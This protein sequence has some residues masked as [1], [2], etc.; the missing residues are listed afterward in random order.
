MT[1]PE[2]SGR[3]VAD[4]ALAV[5]N[6]ERAEGIPIVAD[7]AAAN[8]VDWRQLQRWGISQ[9]RLPP[10]TL[11]LFR[12]PTL[13][14]RHRILILAIIVSGVL[15]TVLVFALIL[16]IRRRWRV[17]KALLQ[18]KTMAEAV[19]ESLPG[20]FLVQDEAGRNLRW[21]KNAAA[22]PRFPLEEAAFP[23]NV[24]ETH[25]EAARKA[26][27]RLLERGT[28]EVEVDLLLRDGKT[29][30]FYFTGKRVELEGKPYVTAI[31]IDL[32]E[33]KKAEE[34]VRRFEGEMR[35]LVENAPYGIGT[36]SLKQD[37][38][39]H[40]NPAMVKLLGYK[41]EAEVLALNVSRDLYS[42]G[43]SRGFRAQHARTDSFSAVEYHWKR[44]DG[45]AVV[46]R[47]S[48]RRV[49]SMEDQDDLMEII[50]EDVTPQRS[51]EEQLRQ[52]QK[53]EAL[54]QLSG[55]VA[56]DFNN[57]LSVIIG[58]S[59]L[60]STEPVFEGPLKTHL[61]AIRRAGER[62]ASLTSQ[63]LAFSRRQMLQP[64]VININLLIRETQKMLQ[65]LMR[66]DIEHSIKLDPGLWKVKAD[67]NQL[68]QV[69][70]NLAINARDAMPNGGTLTIA[71]ANVVFNDVSTIN[72]VDVPAGNYVKLAV[73]D[74]GIGMNEE[75]QGRIF[76][77]FFTTKET[78]KGTGLGL[79]T[80]YGIVKQSGGYIFSDSEVGKGTTLSIYLPQFEK[81]TEAAFALMESGAASAGKVQ[82]E[83]E[84][85][86]VVED[87]AAFRDLLRDGLRAK[88]FNVLVAANG[89]EALRVAE[90]H[91]SSIRLL[92][93]D[94]IM[95][96][97][98]GPE[99]ARALRRTHD[100][101]V[102]YMSGYTDDKLRDM[103]ESGE[104]ALMRKPF[105][106]DELVQRINEVLARRR[107]ERESKI[108]R[109]V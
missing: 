68:V 10:S 32:T 109:M 92:I 103:S 9:T 65:R 5:L 79:A 82:Q 87:E 88:G 100:L 49:R 46:V 11:V 90:Q 91:G 23:E 74:T 105:Y 89:V 40:A 43:T 35:L 16:N 98:S 81:A 3:K 61:E 7:D 54:G 106:L 22:L 48:G 70:M 52:A 37:R 71:T 78:G 93:T 55:S 63:L 4:L 69:I 75:T 83:S 36:I 85:I 50:A 45:T 8:M 86:L 77:P 24:A 67:P 107:V 66:E 96:Q 17:E 18:E 72:G 20:V 15:E 59:E 21:N 108:S 56:H 94:V 31:G 28:G 95:P 84:T 51:L 6:G 39:L 60:L 19:I 34:A 99:L 97:L 33:K 29:A 76:E 104:L 13:W 14:E 41:S 64:S 27:E 44:K 26:R 47:A 58:Y 73:S 25:K 57:L 53:L 80:V 42:D 12:E 1:N 101:P 62:A 30:P 102:L 2:K 38:F